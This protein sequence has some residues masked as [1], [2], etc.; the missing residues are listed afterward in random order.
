MR[1]SGYRFVLYLAS[2]VGPASE[3]GPALP[4]EAG[5]SIDLRERHWCAYAWPEAPGPERPALFVDESGEILKCH[6]RSGPTYHGSRAPKPHAALMQVPHVDDPGTPLD[7][8]RL[9]A[10]GNLWLPI[11]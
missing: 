1:K 7:E 4:G 10:D 3:V 2:D 9:R 8:S 6:V 5:R 11:R